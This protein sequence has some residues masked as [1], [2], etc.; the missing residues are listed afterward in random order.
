MPKLTQKEA[1][2]LKEIYTE[3]IEKGCKVTSVSLA[4]Y[5]GVKPPSVIDMLNKLE[6]KGLIIRVKWSEVK[7]TDKGIKIVKNLL[8]SHRVLEL[9]FTKVLGMDPDESCKEASKIDALVGNEVVVRLCDL[10]G[11]PDK[12][13]HGLPI[14]HIRG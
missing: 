9:Y 2:Y 7:M 8:H 3:C 6:R 13:P 5:M 1:N 4:E 10:L 11:R 12:C 14:Y